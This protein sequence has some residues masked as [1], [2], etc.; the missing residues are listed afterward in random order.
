MDTNELRDLLRDLLPALD[1]YGMTCRLSSFKEGV[2]HWE[3][4]ARYWKAQ[5]LRARVEAVLAAQ[6]E[7]QAA[8]SE[9]KKAD[10]DAVMYG[11]GFMLGGKHIPAQDVMVVQ[12]P[13]QPEAQGG[14]DWPEDAALEN[15]GYVNTCCH[16]G[17]TFTGH[18]RRVTCKK[19]SV[20]TPSTQPKGEVVT[21]EMV[22]RAIEGYWKSATSDGARPG[23]STA[24][25]R[26]AL[27]AALAN[28][29]N[30]NG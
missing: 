23:I 5:H 1:A 27:T 13:Q 11:T 28:K 29:E 16:C 20:L 6:P 22:D 8:L 24:W 7:A 4:T 25:M 3:M 18:K 17:G 9:Q 15:G 12:A 10:L 30:G 26:D 21:D 14:G 2:L 19:C